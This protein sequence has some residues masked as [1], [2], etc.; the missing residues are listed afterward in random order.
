MNSEVKIDILFAGL[1][2]IP[3]LILAIPYIKNK[4]VILSRG[5]AFS[6]IS[7]PI[8]AY[9]IYDISIESNV[10][11]LVGLCVAYIAFFSTYAASISLLAV[12]TKKEDLAQ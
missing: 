9:L 3:V 4:L 8:S 11:G 12:S 10:F 6:I 5:K 2:L 1:L 7:L